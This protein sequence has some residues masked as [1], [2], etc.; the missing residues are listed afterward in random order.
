MTDRSAGEVQL[1]EKERV[2]L[3]YVHCLL[4]LWFGL[5]SVKFVS[6]KM[7]DISNAMAV[8]VAG[9][10]LM[11]ISESESEEGN[12]TGLHDSDL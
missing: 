7:L 4:I 8:A 10:E 5:F 6:Y 3:V 11:D 9:S 2:E 12:E 1:E